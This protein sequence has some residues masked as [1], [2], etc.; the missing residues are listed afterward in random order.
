MPA[1]VCHARVMG[2]DLSR[3]SDR[4]RDDEVITTASSVAFFTLLAIFPAL[5]AVVALVGLFAD[6]DRIQ[7]LIDTLRTVVPQE[8]ADV[9]AQH[10]KKFSDRW[11]SF[12]SN[13]NLLP[14]LGLLML[15][16]SSNTGTKG[17]IRGLNRIYDIE[18]RRGFVRFNLVTLGFTIAGIAFL[19][20]AMAA[21][22]LIPWILR[23][24]ELEGVVRDAFAI[25]RWPILVLLVVGSLALLYRYGPAC[26]GGPWRSVAL[27]SAVAAFLWLLGSLAFSWYVSTFG[28][29]SDTYG[30][31][32]TIIGFMVWVW[33]SA[34]AVLLG[35]EVDAE[36]RKAHAPGQEPP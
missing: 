28:N 32:G 34:T 35:A 18:E 4:I 9:V 20:L 24:I 17:M 30:S 33:L 14:L 36:Y 13:P 8:S 3:Y 11:S 5:S 29:F 31:L 22:L 19:V 26:P 6:P 16:W 21:L 2:V 12:R 15:I 23:S 10:V 7:H 25:V 27:G 1:S